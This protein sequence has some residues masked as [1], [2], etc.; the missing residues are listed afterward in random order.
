MDHTDYLDDF[1]G[2]ENELFEIYNIDR[3]IEDLTYEMYQ[4][5]PN[6]DKYNSLQEEIRE[7]TLT[8]TEKRCDYESKYNETIILFAY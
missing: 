4:C 1:I 6:T 2:K 7:F 8:L 3:L 5:V